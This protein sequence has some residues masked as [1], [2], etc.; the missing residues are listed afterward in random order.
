MHLTIQGTSQL[1]LATVFLSGAED[2]GV[3]CNQWSPA[4]NFKYY[5]GRSD[6]CP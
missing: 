5:H 2:R 3:S 6:L 4:P 1:Q